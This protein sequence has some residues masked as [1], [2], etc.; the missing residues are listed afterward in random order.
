MECSCRLCPSPGMYAVTS[1]PLDRRT[2]ATLRSAEFGF[3]GVMILTCRQTPFFCGQPCMA[4]CFGLRYCWRRGLRTSWLI[5]GIPHSPGSP[6]T[7]PPSRETLTLVGR[8]RRVKGTTD[9]RA[10]VALDPP[11]RG[12][13]G[14]AAYTTVVDRTD[15][16][17]VPGARPGGRRGLG[18]ER[19][20]NSDP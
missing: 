18:G 1:M 5:V 11:R 9:Q 15:Q 17:P 8:G 12:R 20:G 6:Q 4:G 13:Y 16:T 3:L 19:E 14:N 2:R 7:P 10:P